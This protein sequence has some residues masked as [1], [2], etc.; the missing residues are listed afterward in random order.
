PPSLPATPPKFGDRARL[1]GGIYLERRAK[2]PRTKR[3]RLRLVPL[4]CFWGV[5]SPV[6]G[7]SLHSNSCGLWSRLGSL[8]KLLLSVRH[9]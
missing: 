6:Y 7:T 8:R 1:V 2:P 5:R 3:R 4:L 9:Y